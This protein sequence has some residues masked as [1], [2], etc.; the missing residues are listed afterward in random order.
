MEKPLFGYC[1]LNCRECP[2]FIATVNNDEELR[3]STVKEW[4]ALYS[5]YLGQDEL[6][7]EDIHC[8]GCS[9]E[10]SV[11]FIVEDLYKS[12]GE[13]FVTGEIPVYNSNFCMVKYSEIYSGEPES[14]FI[15]GVKAFSRLNPLIKDIVCVCI[16]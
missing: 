10:D 4:T 12:L 1:G 11:N 8:L 7:P 2:V 13:D 9:N 14:C 3:I 15:S 16:I 5:E 6:R